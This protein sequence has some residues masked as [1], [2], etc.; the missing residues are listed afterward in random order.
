M[1]SW[2][3][4]GLMRIKKGEHEKV[5]EFHAQNF[6][7]FSAPVGMIFT[8]DRDMG[9]MSWLDY[10]MFMQNISL[11][12]RGQDLHTCAQAAWGTYHDVIEKHLG[13][14]EPQVVHCGMSLGYEDKT[15]EVNKRETVRE[16][17]EK[18]VTFH[19]GWPS[20]QTDLHIEAPIGRLSTI[21]QPSHRQL[22]EQCFRFPE[23]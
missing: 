18:F 8:I 16:P 15:A 10:G 13:V 23:T 4:Y 21:A 7:F 20:K 11:A 3:L 22:L 1:V 2:D 6:K 5:R 9:W 12:A 19:E 14:P 17:L